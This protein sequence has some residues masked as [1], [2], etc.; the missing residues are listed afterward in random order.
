MIS[1]E[2][3]LVDTSS[4]VLNFLLPPLLGKLVDH[5]K[6]LHLPQVNCVT[7]SNMLSIDLPCIV[8]MTVFV[9]FPISLAVPTLLM[10]VMIATSLVNEGE[11][12]NQGFLVPA[13]QIIVCARFNFCI[14]CGG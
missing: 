4:A 5:F 8:T 10:M 13:H 3:H 14:I 12:P 9:V 1:A 7:Q 2:I 6:L 11:S